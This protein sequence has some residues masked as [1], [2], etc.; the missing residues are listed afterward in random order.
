MILSQVANLGEM[1]NIEAEELVAKTKLQDIVDDHSF[2]VFQPTVH[3]IPLR[4]SKKPMRFSF[5]RNNGLYE[6]DAVMEK[7]YIVDDLRVCR[8]KTVSDVQKRQR[9]SSFR[10][11]IILDAL[12]SLFQP[13]ID[14]PGSH[15]I[16]EVRTS[17]LSDTGM[18]FYSYEYFPG[19]TLIEIHVKLETEMCLYA[20][21]I[22]SYLPTPKTAKYSTSVQFVNLM[23]KDQAQISRFILKTQ[24]KKRNRAR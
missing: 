4:S 20:K 22:R 17:D 5:Y 21:V 12:V 15:A 14:I 1:L 13:E 11:P 9:R 8:F 7:S 19:G 2:I 10:L 3:G 18:Q 23:S 16:F 6:F 24:I